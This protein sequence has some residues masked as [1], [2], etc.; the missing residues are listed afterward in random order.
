MSAAGDRL[1]EFYAATQRYSPQLGGRDGVRGQVDAIL[2]ELQIPASLDK[3]GDWR[4]AADVGNF[5]LL[6]EPETQDL[7]VVQHME[8]LSSRTSKHA[9]GMLL[10]LL[11]NYEARGATFSAVNEGGKKLLM[12]S[13]R[14]PSAG[15]DRAALEGLLADAMRLSR[16]LDEVLGNE[17]AQPAQQPV[18]QPQPQ[19]PAPQQLPP[20]GWHPDPGGAPVQRWWDGQRWTEHT[21]P[22]A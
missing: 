7:V 9:D 8:T 4:L 18:A 17:P 12:L 11:L 2:N 21:T 14:L 5:V 13:A 22:A 15:L 16:R 3:D 1:A 6:L 20:P 10:L 19:P